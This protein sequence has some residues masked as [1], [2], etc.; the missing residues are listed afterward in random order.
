MC[1][2]LLVLHYNYDCLVLFLRINV[3]NRLLLHVLPGR[4]T[5]NEI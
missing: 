4:P 1:K 2:F 3:E 5:E